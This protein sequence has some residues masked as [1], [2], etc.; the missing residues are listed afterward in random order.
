MKFV[1][2]ALAIAAGLGACNSGGGE[3]APANETAA[4]ASEQNAGSAPLEPSLN[5]QMN[6]SEATANGSAAAGQGPEGWAGKW[7][8]VEGL[9]LEVQK[10]S[11]PGKYTLRIDEGQGW[12]TYEGTAEGST[13][14]F[15]RNGKDATLRAAS[16]A[17]TGLK[18]LAD[19]KDCLMVEQGLGFCRDFPEQQ[20]S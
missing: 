5:E 6:G 10:A 17:E 20:Q 16:G 14:R 4:A 1:V 2:P 9:A 13:I 18:W 19:R 3:S 12:Q 11:A 15:T 8:G 7:R